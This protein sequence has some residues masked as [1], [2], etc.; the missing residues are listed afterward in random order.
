MVAQLV[1]LM[2]KI[3]VVWKVVLSVDL[4]VDGMVV[5]LVAKSVD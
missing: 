5:L 2:G 4:L 3:T 1:V